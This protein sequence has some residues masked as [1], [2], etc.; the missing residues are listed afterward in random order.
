MKYEIYNTK[1]QETNVLCN[2]GV[3]IGT[4]DLDQ[5]I[6]NHGREL[7][8]QYIYSFSCFKCLN[9]S[10]LTCLECGHQVC[11]SCKF[12][13]K[14]QYSSVQEVYCKI[15]NKHILIKQSKPN[16]EEGSLIYAHLIY[17][18]YSKSRAKST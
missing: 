11:E 10:K 2:C 7:I 12:T 18:L 17:I 6:G 9:K 4:S 3:R 5:L 13:L 14:R 15:C 1:T 8:D 16:K